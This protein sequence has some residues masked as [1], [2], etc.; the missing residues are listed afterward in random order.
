MFFQ[1][2]G[3][4]CENMLFQCVKRCQIG[5]LQNVKLTFVDM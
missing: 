4:E 2:S 3:T 5:Y 1:M